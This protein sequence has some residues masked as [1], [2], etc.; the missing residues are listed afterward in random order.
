MR[1]PETGIKDGFEE[2]EHEIPFGIFHPEKQD[3]LFR[4]SVTAGNFPQERTKN[5]SSIHFPI[6]FS[7]NFL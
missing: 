4:R 5:S 2:M 7:G 1:R 6:R 3:H